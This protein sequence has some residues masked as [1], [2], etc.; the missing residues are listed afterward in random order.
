MSNGQIVEGSIEKETST[1]IYVKTASGMRKLPIDSIKHVRVGYSGIPICLEKTNEPGQKC[2][3]YLHLITKDSIYTFRGANATKL[4]QLKLENVKYLEFKKNK[5]QSISHII[6]V[7]S[8]LKFF[9]TDPKPLAGTILE[10]SNKSF[11]VESEDGKQSWIPENQ[12]VKGSYSSQEEIEYSE[13][14]PSRFRFYDLLIPGLYQGRQNQKLKSRFMFSL[15]GLLAAGTAYE[16]AQ[17][18]A[19][20]DK[21]QSELTVY[22]YGDKLYVFNKNDYSEFEMHKREN[23]AFAGTLLILYLYNSF[24]IFRSKDGVK[25]GVKAVPQTFASN[26]YN[27]YYEI[28]VSYNF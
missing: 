28:S 22:P 8:K 3:L 11:H 7:G 24:D 23:N 26:R 17:A 15:F 6:Q 1:Y 4:D 21:A 16:Y 19:A 12:I 14:T 25:V 27:T 20:K 13:A 10:I 9:T 2:D 5:S 18:R